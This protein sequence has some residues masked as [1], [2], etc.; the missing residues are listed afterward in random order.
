MTSLDSDPI[1]ATIASHQAA[2]QAVDT[3]HAGML[4]ALPDVSDADHEIMTAAIMAEI[5]AAKVMVSTVPTTRG[6]LQAFADYLREERQHQ[7]AQHIGQKVA[8]D[9]TSWGMPGA[10]EGLIARRAAEI[11]LAV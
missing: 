3:A 10:V 9:G 5:G 8:L 6:G 11:A 4:T 2:A 1:H 7:V